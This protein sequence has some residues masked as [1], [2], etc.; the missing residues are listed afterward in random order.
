MLTVGAAA[1]GV[2]D[3]RAATGDDTARADALG[4][5]IVATNAFTESVTSC[6]HD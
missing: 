2:N 6:T 1:P 3:L 4:G 5:K